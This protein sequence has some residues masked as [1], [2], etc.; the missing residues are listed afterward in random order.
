MSEY[1]KKP[2]VIEAI[3]Y[4]G[5]NGN[6]IAEFMK[7]M[8]PAY[9]ENK[10]ILIGTLEGVMSA[11]KGDFIIKGV[12]GEFY[13]CKPD[14]FE[15]TYLAYQ[16]KRKPLPDGSL[17]MTDEELLE[18]N[19]IVADFIKRF[20]QITY[21][22]R[23]KIYEDKVCLVFKHDYTRDEHLIFV[24]ELKAILYLATLFDL[25]VK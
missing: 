24:S 19:K 15:K 8:Y 6:E 11:S 10:N 25:E 18:F 20:F 7:C 5:E 14:I 22:N 17:P 2:V 9:D 16:P 12:K 3:E 23:V 4:N 1:V 21:Q 13:P